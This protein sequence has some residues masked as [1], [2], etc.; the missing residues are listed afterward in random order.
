M[1]LESVDFFTRPTPALV[2]SNV[3]LLD[4]M[5]SASVVVTEIFL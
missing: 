1:Y 5:H 2:K 4:M 3:I